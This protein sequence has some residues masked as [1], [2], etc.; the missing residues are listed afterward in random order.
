MYTSVPSSTYCAEGQSTRQPKYVFTAY[1]DYQMSLGFFGHIIIYRLIVLACLNRL[2]SSDPISELLDTKPNFSGPVQPPLT[3]V[4]DAYLQG[5]I[6]MTLE[7]SQLWKSFS[8][9]GTEMI[10]TKPGR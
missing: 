6:R 1:S 8:E 3:G 7:D 9:I 4:P 5:N 10:I 2:D